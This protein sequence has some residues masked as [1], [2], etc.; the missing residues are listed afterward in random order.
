M[1]KH[2]CDGCE[3]EL[4]TLNYWEK[5]KCSQGRHGEYHQDCLIL[6]FGELYC[7]N[8]SVKAE[9]RKLISNYVAKVWADMGYAGA[10]SAENGV[11]SA[12]VGPLNMLIEPAYDADAISLTSVDLNVKGLTSRI[13]TFKASLCDHDTIV[14][15]LQGA[16]VRSL[17]STKSSITMKKKQLDEDVAKMDVLIAELMGKLGGIMPDDTSISAE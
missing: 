12:S 2:F 4:V 15:Q 17:R 10:V 11:V 13:K 1:E 7:K 16:I 3:K 8:H 9:N 14:K 6:V 5:T